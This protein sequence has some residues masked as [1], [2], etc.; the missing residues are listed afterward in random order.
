MQDLQEFP[1]QVHFTGPYSWPGAPDAPCLFE[2]EASRKPGIYLWTVQVQDGFL[3][4]YVGETGRSHATRMSEH[5]REH[6]AGMYHVYSP[7]EFV[8][9]RKVLLWPGRYNR[10]DR[11]SIPDC[12]AAYPQLA[13]HIHALSHAYRFFLA[14][15]SSTQRARKRIE[16]AIADSLYGTPGFVGEFQDRGIR[17]DRRLSTELSFACKVTATANLLALPSEVLA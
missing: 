15:V 8:S 7:A 6:A 9:G 10:A 5:Y 1:T 12:I 14:S 16:A 11:K 13:T 2:E 17:Y 4:Y 3:I